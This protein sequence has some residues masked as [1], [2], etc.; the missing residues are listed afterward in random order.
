LSKSVYLKDIE[1]ILEDVLKSGGSIK[2]MPN[3]Q[4]MLPLIREGKD[5]VVISPVERKPKK[6]DTILYKRTN[7]QFVLHRIVRAKKNSYV[8]CGD[9]QYQYEYDITDDMIIGIMTEFMRDGKTITPSDFQYK[10]YLKKLYAKR[11]VKRIIYLARR[12][13]GKIKRTITGVKK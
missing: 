12:V 8:L 1:P 2:F 11:V 4:S 7:G 13:L 9:N 3:G 10:I 6:Y 5:S